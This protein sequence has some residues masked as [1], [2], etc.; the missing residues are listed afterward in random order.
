VK[1]ASATNK[2][3]LLVVRALGLGDFLTAVPAYRGLERAFPEYHRVL[4][5]PL[6]LAPLAQLCGAFDE[7]VDTAPLAALDEG[8]A[9][10]DVAVNM[11]GRG[12][13]SHRLILDTQP[14]RMLA[15]RCDDVP[16]ASEGPQWRDDEHEVQRWCRMLDAFGVRCEA[17]D[18]GLSPP[19]YKGRHACAILLHVGAASEARRWPVHRWVE[20]T[21]R[22]LSLGLR[23]AFTGTAHE[24][25]RARM[26][27]RYSGAG[28]ESVVAGKLDLAQAASLVKSA[29]A[30]V[31]GDTG[32]A[33]LATSVG[34]PSVVLFG[35][36]SPARWGP[37]PRRKQHRAI[38]HG[39]LGDP[40]GQCIDPGL[41]DIE[42]DE[43]YRALLDVLRECAA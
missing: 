36:E 7:V 38:W 31:C 4:A 26:V 43:V 35:P 32:M 10:A 29:R 22:L 27:A 14:R 16:F 3:R 20:L 25:R 8:L 18:L 30:V 19:E 21:K 9:R 2:P 42:I 15:F 41:A 12:P 13:Q 6:A 23:V 37:P 28:V 40:H 33:H 1:S 17:S 5:A 39:R 24:F 11:H 34:T